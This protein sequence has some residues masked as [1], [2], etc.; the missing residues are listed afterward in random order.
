MGLEAHVNTVLFDA[1]DVFY[2]DYVWSNGLKIGGSNK[3]IRKL[4]A[5]K[6]MKALDNNGEFGKTSFDEETRKIEF[7]VMEE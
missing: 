2:E 1:P 7:E 6:I 3:I 4:R 5:M